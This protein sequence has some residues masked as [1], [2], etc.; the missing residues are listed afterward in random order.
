LGIEADGIAPVSVH[1]LPDVHSEVKNMRPRIDI[2]EFDRWISYAFDANPNLDIG[3]ALGRYVDQYHVLIQTSADEPY[4]ICRA[5]TKL[6]LIEKSCFLRD[7]LDTDKPPIFNTKLKEYHS[8]L[9]HDLWLYDNM[10]PD[11]RES[12]EA[13]YNEGIV[14]EPGRRLLKIMVTLTEWLVIGVFGILSMLCAGAG[15]VVILNFPSVVLGR[16]EPGVSQN[17]YIFFFVYAVVFLLVLV[18]G[19]LKPADKLFD[20]LKRLKNRL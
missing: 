17:E 10:G 2:V 14:R 15:L 5:R 19:I 20:R 12:S 13:I 16:G 7:S 1:L 6:Y 18:S 8:V 4:Q 9:K 3:S 11:T